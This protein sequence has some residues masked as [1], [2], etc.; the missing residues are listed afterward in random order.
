MVTEEDIVAI[1]VAPRITLADLEDNI[2]SEHYFTAKDGVLFS[3]T[4]EESQNISESLGLLTFCVLVLKNGYTVTGQS[5]C[6]SKENYNKAI[7]QDLAK[8]D[9]KNKIW[10]LMGYELRSKLQAEAA[11]YPV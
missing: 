5:A 4:K 2:L 10:A 11:A 8:S 3:A 7:G 6:A 9:A 1:T